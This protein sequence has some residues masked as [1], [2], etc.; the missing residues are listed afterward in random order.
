MIFHFQNKHFQ[1]VI[2]LSFIFITVNI[3]NYLEPQW[4]RVFCACVWYN[5]ILHH[6]LLDLLSVYAH[7]C[8]HTHTQQ[9]QVTWPY[10]L[11]IDHIFHEKYYFWW[12]L[13]VLL[14]LLEIR[15]FYHK[16][17]LPNSAC[18]FASMCAAMRHINCRTV[19]VV[20]M[21]QTHI[22]EFTSLNSL[23]PVGR[24]QHS[25]LIR[26]CHI[27]ILFNLSFIIP[28]HNTKETKNKDT[29]LYPMGK[30]VFKI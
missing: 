7:T 30:S 3:L 24:C 16:Q 13:T 28:P 6:S 26:P 17:A 5:Q 8:I 18:P 27:E 9:V 19:R 20:V 4:R 21:F 29:Q 10:F 23:L 12:D 22:W 14:C 1:A 11:Q 15:A 2:I 25:I